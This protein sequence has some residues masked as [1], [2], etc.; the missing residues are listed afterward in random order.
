MARDSGN[1]NGSEGQQLDNNQ[2]QEEEEA[3]ERSAQAAKLKGPRGPENEP[4]NCN[5]SRCE[6]QQLDQEEEGEEAGER[7]PQGQRS[8]EFQHATPPYP[9]SAQEDEPTEHGQVDEDKKNEDCL[10]PATDQQLDPPPSDA[11]EGGE[12]GSCEGDGS[13][14]ALANQ[15]P[16]K[17]RQ[18]GAKAAAVGRTNKGL[19]R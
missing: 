2:D 9:A 10:D 16:R 5:G 3:G 8:E 6:G 13:T 11:G 14:P 4:G 18:R 7:P 19:K 15:A 17:R 1:C 12:E